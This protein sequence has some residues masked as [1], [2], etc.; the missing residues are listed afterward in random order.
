MENQPKL[1]YVLGLGPSLSNFTPNG[2]PTIGVNDINYQ[3]EKLGKNHVVDYLVI[4]DQATAFNFD[5][6]TEI[7]KRP[8]TIK[9]FSPH[10]PWSDSF[11]NFEHIRVKPYQIG[12]LD[13]PVTK[14]NRWQIPS[15][16]DST[17]IACVI[18]VRLGFENIVIFGADF[19]DHPELS[20]KLDTILNQF[21]L[22][23]L[24]LKQ[25]GV[26]L[27]CSSKQSQLSRVLTVKHL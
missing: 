17:F 5:R 24:K 10:T 9:A 27:Y 12:I 6:Y 11:Q 20:K 23:N 26:N 22:L 2:T 16:V 1:I 13:D 21:D 14:F 19:G 25:K 15:S 18:A 3:L 7:V 8:P 4:Q